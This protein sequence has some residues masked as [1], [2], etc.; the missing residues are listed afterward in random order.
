[1]TQ[2]QY[3]QELLQRY[4]VDGSATCPLTK[5]EEPAEEDLDPEGIRKAQN[6]TG[7]LLWAVTRSRPDLSFV[8]SLMAQYSTKT[9]GK[10][11]EMGLQALRYACTTLDL[12]LEYRRVE[13]PPLGR[14]DSSLCLGPVRPSKCTRMRVIHRKVRGAGSAW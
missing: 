14:K 6:I 7:A 10:V 11:F 4:S 5:W 8:L 1:M 9:P 13:V 2:K 3:L 12:G